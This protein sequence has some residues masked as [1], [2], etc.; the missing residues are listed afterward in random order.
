MLIRIIRL[1][2]MWFITK[3]AMLLPFP[4]GNIVVHDKLLKAIDSKEEFAAPLAHEYSHVAYRHTTRSLFRNFGYLSGCITLTN[5][6]KWS[7][8]C[9]VAKCR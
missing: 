4:G 2:Y 3:S 5:R 7:N 1:L 6:C 9:F 8:G